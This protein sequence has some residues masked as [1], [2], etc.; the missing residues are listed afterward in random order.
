MK[1]SAVGGMKLDAGGVHLLRSL[2]T[3]TLLLKLGI[4]GLLLLLYELCLKV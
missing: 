4:N 3:L 1:L 2:G